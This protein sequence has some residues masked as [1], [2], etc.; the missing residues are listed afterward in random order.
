MN[1]NMLK[2]S[3]EYLKHY[4]LETQAYFFYFNKDAVHIFFLFFLV[5]IL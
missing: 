3:N 2:D 5:V 4:K 1:F